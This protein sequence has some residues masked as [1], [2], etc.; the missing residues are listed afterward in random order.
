MGETAGWHARERAL[1]V[2]C[3]GCD[4]NRKLHVDELVDSAWGTGQ[5]KVRDFRTTQASKLGAGRGL[6]VVGAAQ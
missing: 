3:T 1:G 6:S 5:P 4:V 2:L